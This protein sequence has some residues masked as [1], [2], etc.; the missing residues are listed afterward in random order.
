MTVFA[1]LIR[2][3]AKA[4]ALASCLIV[5]ACSSDPGTFVSYGQR[6]GSGGARFDPNRAPRRTDALALNYANSIEEIFRARSTGA[7]YTR[8]A[9]DTALKGLAVFAGAAKSLDIGAAKL[10]KMGLASAGILDLRSIFDAKGRSTAYFEAAERIHAAIKDF[11]AHNLN[12]I[13][14][15]ELTPNGWTL[16]NVVQSNIDIVNKILNGHLPSPEALAQA[17]EAMTEEGA[18]S[19]PTGTTPT[20]NIP[21]G[22]LMPAVAR[23]PKRP[24]VTTDKPVHVVEKSHNDRVNELLGRINNLSEADAIALAKQR[25][26]ANPGSGD[27]AKQLIYEAI[28]AL[29]NNNDPIALGEW[30]NALPARDEY[31]KVVAGLYERVANLTDPQAINVVKTEWNIAETN[32]EKARNKIRAEVVKLRRLKMPAVAAK[33][34][35]ALRAEETKTP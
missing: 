10:A 11:G 33:W 15:T 32:G 7:R 1:P 12:N 35:E 16:V 13:S 20:N 26:N 29:K 23:I 9:S 5:A 31:Q 17:S 27:A 19:Q 25:L 8:E 18:T 24:G 22:E 34:D 21:A 3:F 4:G 6:H 30:G 14:E 28:A 2:F